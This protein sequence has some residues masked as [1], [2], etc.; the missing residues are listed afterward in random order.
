MECSVRMQHAQCQSRMDST[1]RLPSRLI[2]A[3]YSD[4]SRPPSRGRTPLSSTSFHRTPNCMFSF[5]GQA[6]PGQIRP[7]SE[8]P[9][10]IR[11]RCSSRLSQTNQFLR[12]DS[13][14]PAVRSA[15]SHFHTN[16]WRRHSTAVR[17]RT[18]LPGAGSRPFWT[19]QHHWGRRLI[20]LLPRLLDT[21]RY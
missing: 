7:N 2:Y 12:R 10:N 13:F 20:E 6:R 3:T 15:S 21:R 17:N 8:K 14:A 11:F 5:T 9:L 19:T 4:H 18:S 1:E 16:P